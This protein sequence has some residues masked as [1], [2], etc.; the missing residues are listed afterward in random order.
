MAL[1]KGF[2]TRAFFF[3]V[4]DAVAL[5]LSSLFSFLI[6]ESVTSEAVTFPYRAAGALILL[7]VF[8]LAYFRMYKVSWRFTSLRELIMLIS[9]LS[10]STVVFI[11]GL[12]FMGQQS[13]YL[14][15]FTVLVFFQSILLIGAFR[16]SK[17]LNLEILQHQKKG[18]RA[19]IFG[20]GNAGD[21]IMRDIIR[22]QHWNLKILAI[23]DDSPSL[24][25]LSMHG[26]PV[27]GDRQKMYQ[28][29]RYT[30]IDELIIA[31]PSLPKPELK[32][33][34]EKVKQVAPTL[35]IKV[36]PSFHLLSDDPVGVKNIREISI[37]D[38]LGREPARID[39]ESVR[40]GI[41]GKK[42]LITGAGGSIGR[43]I[44]KQCV[45]LGASR[46]LALEV[47]ETEVF[48]VLNEFQDVKQTI[49]PCVANILDEER[50]DRILKV[51]KPDII[52]HAAAYKHVPMMERFPGEAIKLN[53]EGTRIVADLACKHDV[54]KFILISTDKAVN[55][56][57]VMGATKRI[58]EEICLSL[59]DLCITKFIAV[60]FGNV[61]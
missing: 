39:M 52:F 6:L 53:V 31:I 38:I 45:G 3:I 5:I 18:K 28:F 40:S 56:T 8:S 41:F 51:E 11:V 29:L 60:R 37:E 26:V 22:H 15:S 2:K 19:V 9:A 44:V 47:D 46:V 50:I 4:G 48:N 14:I 59:N 25:G 57:N 30:E 33:V 35:K 49:E 10:V 21:Q 16:I 17:R 54:D 13:S 36:L 12:A 42:V 34:I 43:E 55:P 61:L 24:H 1:I 7:S 58:A 23:F 32:S 20:A 27:K